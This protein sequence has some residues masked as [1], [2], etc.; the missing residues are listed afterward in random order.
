VLF[1]FLA[2]AYAYLR[3]SYIS[4][5]IAHFDQCFAI[6]RPYL[7]STTQIEMLA[8]YV[9]ITSKGDYEMLLKSLSDVADKQRSSLPQFI[10]L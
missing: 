10:V 6:C 9:S 7:D 2:C 4:S 3:N 5:A 8:R 1:L